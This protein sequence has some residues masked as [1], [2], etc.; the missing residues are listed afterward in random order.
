VQIGVVALEVWQIV[1]ASPEALQARH[2]PLVAPAALQI[3]VLGFSVLHCANVPHAL[4]DPLPVLQ[5][6]FAALIPWQSWSSA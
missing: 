5:I 4:H 1:A 6:G 2:C 3:G